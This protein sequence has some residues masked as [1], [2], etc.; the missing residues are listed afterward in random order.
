M[1]NLPSR[2][3]LIRWAGKQPQIVGADRKTARRN[4]VRRAVL[5]QSRGECPSFEPLI[6]TVTS[7]VLCS[8]AETIVAARV[9]QLSA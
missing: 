3:N 6:D 7:A 1:S 4:S 2:L 9:L 8:T 5:N